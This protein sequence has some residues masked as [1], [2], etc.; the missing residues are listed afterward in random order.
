MPGAVNPVVVGVNGTYR[1]IRAA[2]WAAAVAQ[3]FA[4]PL[5]IVNAKPYLGH[6]LSDAVA[7]LRAAE[8]TA[9][10]DSA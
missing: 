2:R 4:A 5:H 10:N 1:A 3:K 9:Q 7:N 6:N 8:M